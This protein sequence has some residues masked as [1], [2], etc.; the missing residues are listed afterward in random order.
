MMQF[1]SRLAEEKIKHALAEGELDNLPGH[2]KPLALEDFS[3]APEHL[4][5]AY[6]ILKNAG[7]LPLEV[8]LRKEIAALQEQL[9]ASQDELQ[10]QRLR[11]EINDKSLKYNLLMERNQRRQQ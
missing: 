4:R 2:G 9:E 6:Q 10:Q 8:E 3:E 7:V 1:L 5:M 11:K